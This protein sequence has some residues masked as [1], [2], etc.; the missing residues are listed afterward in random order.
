LYNEPDKI[1]L[2]DLAAKVA[3]SHYP[4][5]KIEEKF[6]RIIPEPIQRRIIYWSFPQEEKDIIMYSSL[7]SD[8][9]KVSFNRGQTIYRNNLVHNV[10]HVGK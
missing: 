10:L 6:E 1:K 8:D 4:F 9:Q 5:Q 3:A 2:M 7:N